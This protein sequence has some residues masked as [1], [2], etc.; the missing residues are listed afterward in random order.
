MA[1]LND[2]RRSLQRAKESAKQ[3]LQQLDEERREIKS[4]LKSLNAALKA[5]DGAKI[6]RVTSSR[7]TIEE[8]TEMVAELIA[9]E[10]QKSEAELIEAISNQLVESRKSPAGLK[11]MLETALGHDRFTLSAGKYDINPEVSGKESSTFHDST[12]FGG[13]NGD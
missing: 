6:S 11:R 2:A 10:G 13:E 12:E 7:A 8:M 4:S 5:L 3:R 1:K 9:S